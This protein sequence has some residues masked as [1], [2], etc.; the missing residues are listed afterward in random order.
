MAAAMLANQATAQDDQAST[1]DSDEMMLE[2]VVVTGIRSSIERA[3]VIKREADSVVDVITAQDIGQF[4]DYS[5]AEA[6]M[7]VPGVQVETNDSGTAGARVSIRGMGSQYVTTTINNRIMLSGGTE[8]ATNLRSANLDVLPPEVFNG[9]LIRK[10]PTADNP[11]SGMAGQVDMQTLRPLDAGRL[12]NE[13]FYGSVTGRYN[14]NDYIDGKGWRLSG[15]LA[16]R[17]EDATFGYYVSA[18]HSEGD[19]GRDQIRNN[20]R[21]RNLRIDDDGDGAPDRT[22]SALVP[23]STIMSPIDEEQER[24]GIAAAIQFRPN[25]SFELLADVAY[26]TFY[27]DSP[28]RKANL[29]WGRWDL[30]TIQAAG[31]G[32]NE[33]GIFESLDWSQAFPDGLA[34][35][36]RPA[37]DNSGQIFNNH[38]ETLVGGINAKWSKGDLDVAADLYYSGVE[39]S[40]NLRHIT[41]RA[42]PDIAFVSYDQRS[43]QPVLTWGEDG[44]D[45]AN[46]AWK[47]ALIREIELN[48]DHVGAA[49]DFD[50]QLDKGIW[51]SIAFGT[52]YQTTDIETWRSA[53]ARPNPTGDLRAAVVAAAMDGSMAGVDFLRGHGGTVSDW[54]YIDFAAA[55]EVYP[56]FLLTGKDAL[57]TDVRSSYGI[58][59]DVF[60]LYLQAN[61]AGDMGNIPFTGNIGLRPVQTKTT[62]TGTATPDGGEPVPIETKG[63]YWSYL[64]NLNL[65]FSLRENLAMRVG[66]AQTLSRPS[67]SDIAPIITVNVIDEPVDEI[68]GSARAGNPDLDPMMAWIYDL[69]FEYYNDHD[70]AYVLSLFYKDVKDFVFRFSTEAEVPGQEGTFLVSMPQ[71]YSD[72]TV[73]GYEIGLYQPFTMFSS[74]WDRFGL[75]ANYTYVD[76][77]FEEDV[78]NSGYGFPGSSKH[79]FNAIAFYE[80]EKLSVRVTYNNRSDYFRQLAGTGAQGN[81]ARFTE[82]YSQWNL[83]VNYRFNL[84]W[85]MQFGVQNITENYRR[86]FAG[87]NGNFYDYFQRGRTWTL[88]ATFRF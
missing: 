35:N 63:S 71:N 85:A 68:A 59:E 25:D 52:R 43:P 7:R 2:E 1:Q 69:T 77:S 12:R 33:D 62:G 49:L 45:A 64:P 60:A 67:L 65:N 9:V 17:N 72:G 54:P 24:D 39:Y 88:G 84:Q 28:R 20:P 57:G 13:T 32:F 3:T 26:A 61:M 31:I 78:G 58:K 19:D 14:Y 46:Y 80:Q 15:V 51:E 18:V 70:G 38:T 73:K 55:A 81:E 34:G 82:G 22:V 23:A 42:Y 11:E 27:N 47:A 56:D 87:V 8:G 41:M 10:T 76:S 29:F 4:T 21:Q 66:I 83:N 44:Y 40:Q 86:D 6:I 75:Q 5:I 50:Y 48:G 37:I 36:R 53:V 79:N 74:P 30:A 16:G